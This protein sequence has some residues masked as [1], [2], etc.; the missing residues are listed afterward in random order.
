MCMHSTYKHES[1]VVLVELAGPLTGFWD[2]P[3]LHLLPRVTASL[4][5]QCP[6]VK[7]CISVKVGG[8]A[9]SPNQEL[10]K[11]TRK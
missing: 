2:S 4:R 7:G 3:S 5:Q 8:N 6:S 11:V 10:P 1:Y 9:Q